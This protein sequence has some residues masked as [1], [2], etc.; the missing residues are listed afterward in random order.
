MLFLLQMKR[1]FVS[2]NN[3]Y[4]M[5]NYNYENKLYEN[6]FPVSYSK[7]PDLN[8][9]INL[10]NIII[11]NGNELNEPLG[12]II[13]YIFRFILENKLNLEKINI[14]QNG[15]LKSII[16]QI[17]S[18]QIQKENKD[19]ISI[20]NLF[21]VETLYNQNNSN[22]DYN[23]TNEALIHPLEF[24]LNLFNEK[25]LNKNNLIY[26]YFLLLNIKENNEF[27]NH[28]LG[29]DEYDYI[30]D[31]FECALFIILKYFLIFFFF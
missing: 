2:I 17:L 14:L 1:K 23:I 28:G 25:I 30:F 16:L 26:L 8:N 18:K 10:L 29:L 4:S 3:I 5:L 6:Y 24:I 12:H 21:N 9:L 7:E 11:N 22:L 15:E 13:A 27:Y 19:I 20:N 31:N